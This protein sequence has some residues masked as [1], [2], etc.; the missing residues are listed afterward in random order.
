[1]NHRLSSSFTVIFSQS[2]VFAVFY[3]HSQAFTQS[4]TGFYEHSQSF[5]SLSWSCTVIYIPQSSSTFIHSHLQ[6]FTGIHEHS[7]I[8][9]HSQSSTVIH[10]HFHSFTLIQSHLRSCCHFHLFSV[11]R[12]SSSAKVINGLKAV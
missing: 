5:H 12:M 9:G 11:F 2:Q 3:R 8:I 6:S 1:M 4:F 7:V 10:I